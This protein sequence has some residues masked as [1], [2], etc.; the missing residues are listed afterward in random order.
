MLARALDR[1]ATIVKGGEVA[2]PTIE[3]DAGA[4]PLLII[5]AAEMEDMQAAFEQLRAI[6]IHKGAESFLITAHTHQPEGL[7]A[8]YVAPG[9]A[10]GLYRAILREPDLSFAADL[11][12]PE[13]ALAEMIAL[14]PKPGETN[15]PGI[16]KRIRSILSLHSQLEPGTPLVIRKA[17]P[18]TLS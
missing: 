7:M 18:S 8:S 2:L 6:M 12:V 9:G 1:A 16:E 5:I 4:D 17:D 14:R 15:P 10:A 11:V 3:I 13:N